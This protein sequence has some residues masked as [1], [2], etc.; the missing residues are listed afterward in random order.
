MPSIDEKLH[1]A[2][3]ALYKISGECTLCTC[4]KNQD[5]THK[6]Y[7]PRK[8]SDEALAFIEKGGNKWDSL[9]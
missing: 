9:F 8:I 6:E 3:M 4:M 7:C 1:I 2:A 5:G